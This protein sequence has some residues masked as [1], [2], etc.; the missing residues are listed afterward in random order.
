MESRDEADRPGGREFEQR[1]VD[2]REDMDGQGLMFSVADRYLSP[3]ESIY[4]RDGTQ[5]MVS[6]SNRCQTV[7]RS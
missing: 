4:S 2:S 1:V 5:S 3:G 6:K 7:Y